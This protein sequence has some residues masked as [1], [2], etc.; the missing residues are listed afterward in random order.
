MI[1]NPLKITVVFAMFS[2]VNAPLPGWQMATAQP[3]R[4]A[5]RETTEK[6]QPGW[7]LYFLFFFIRFSPGFSP[8]FQGFSPRFSGDIRICSISGDCRYSQVH[9]IC[10]V[11]AATD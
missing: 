1:V 5:A 3:D 6:L 7:I 11:T 8:E 9:P 4:S 2:A 10:C